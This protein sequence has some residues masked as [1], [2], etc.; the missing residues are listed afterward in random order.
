M[1]RSSKFLF[2]IV[3]L[4]GVGFAI[5]STSLYVSGNV[6][7]TSNDSD[8]DIKFTKSILDGVDVSNSTISSDGKL[9]N[10]S[11]NDLSDRKSVV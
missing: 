2:V 3:L 9:I 10:F 11:T 7:I 4:L 6:G 1:K 8:F 5:I